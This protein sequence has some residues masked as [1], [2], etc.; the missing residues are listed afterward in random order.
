VEESLLEAVV[1][2][3]EEVVEGVRRLV[4]DP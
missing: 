1:L 3:S 2:R 4:E